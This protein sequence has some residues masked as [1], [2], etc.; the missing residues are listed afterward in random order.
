MIACHDND[1][2][3]SRQIMT[4]AAACHDSDSRDCREIRYK[5]CR[6][7]LFNPDRPSSVTLEAFCLLSIF[8][9]LIVCTGM[10]FREPCH[11]RV[12]VRVVTY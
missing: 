1:S 4:H 10:T 2:R 11:T 3:D 5:D 8:A 6:I 12:A 9:C 7:T